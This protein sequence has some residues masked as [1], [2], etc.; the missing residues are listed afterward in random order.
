MSLDL[1]ALVA[2]AGDGWSVS[3]GTVEGVRLAARI[4]GWSEVSLRSTDTPHG[5]LRPLSQEEGARNS[6]SAVHGLGE[7]PLHTDGAHLR[8]PPDWIALIVEK[9]NATPTK[10][11]RPPGG[12]NTVPWS[13]FLNGVFLIK[14]GA[15]R[16]LESIGSA[17]RLRYDPTCMTP[18][19]RRAAQAAAF[20]STLETDIR[21]HSWSRD[22]EVLLINN[23][24]VLH[25][26]AAVID[27]ADRHT[28]V[29]HRLAFRR[30][31]S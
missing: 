30:E 8:R 24:K 25:A 27:P 21:E 5:I 17:G 7:Q 23:R 22:N 28:R 12:A 3:Q 20:F 4:L 16:F 26:R 19:D 10:L 14:N 31:L 15:D 1:P 18:C 9:A 6:L 29:I 2:A 13:A 11:W